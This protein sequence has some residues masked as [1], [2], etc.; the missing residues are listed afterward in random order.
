ME[1]YLWMPK[2]V[3]LFLY[4][5]SIYFISITKLLLTQRFYSF[6]NSPPHANHDKVKGILLLEYTHLDP[7]GAFHF[8]HGATIWYFPQKDW[9]ALL[10]SSACVHSGYQVLKALD[11][12]CKWPKKNNIP[13]I[14]SI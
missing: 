7:E 5:L 12:A 6:S 14:I 10:F 1:A 11:P 4:T 9:S 2:L 3:C 13:Q 8:Q